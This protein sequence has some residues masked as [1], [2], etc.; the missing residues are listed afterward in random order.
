MYYLV[1]ICIKNRFVSLVDYIVRFFVCIFLCVLTLRRELTRFI[2]KQ[3]QF[4]SELLMKF[5]WRVIC[6]EFLH[7]D[8]RKLTFYCYCS[9]AV[10]S[11]TLGKE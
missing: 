2:S 11:R 4:I 5:A 9:R 7:V 6:M 10:S 8:E 3:C 1:L